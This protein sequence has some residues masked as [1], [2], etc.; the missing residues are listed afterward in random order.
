MSHIK[1]TPDEEGTS[2]ETIVP[3][4]PQN[5]PQNNPPGPAPKF[6]GLIADATSLAKVIRDLPRTRCAACSP[7]EGYTE[8]IAEILANQ[9]E[10]GDRAGVTTTDFA[11]FQEANDVCAQI[12]VLLPVT[13]K[14]A[15]MLQETY[16]LYEDKR[17]RFTHTLAA[18]VERRA[19]RARMAGRC[20]PGTRRR[21]R[22]ALPSGSRP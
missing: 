16:A 22:I 2:G 12:Q 10:W 8:V 4:D 5:D 15:E 13:L 1:P 14:L 3:N 6:G 21:V 7:P 18:S 19:K 17:Q 11:E 9:P 20:S